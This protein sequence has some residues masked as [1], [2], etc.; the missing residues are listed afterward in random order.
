MSVPAVIRPGRGGDRS[1]IIN[2]WVRSYAKRA[3]ADSP[4]PGGIGPPRT[5]A[6]VYVSSQNRLVERLLARSDI[7]VACGREDSDQ[8]FGYIAY[9][10]PNLLHYLYVKIPFRRLGIGRLLTSSVLDNFP[11]AVVVT[12][13][14]PS[15]QK[16]LGDGV[17]IEFNPYRGYY[18]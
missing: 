3:I 15:V 9:E 18:E 12:H 17:E 13:W 11:R 7:L 5:E 2:S 8:I 14:S 6:A 10:D 1:F 16:V 4:Q